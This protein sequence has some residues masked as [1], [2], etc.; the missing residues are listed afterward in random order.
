MTLYEE[1]YFDIT[2]CGKKSDLKKFIDYIRSG[3][4]DD[5]FEIDPEYI[6][7][8]ET[9]DNAPIDC[10]D[11]VS[12][13]I[14]NDDYAIE[15]E[16]LDVYDFLDSFC[17]AARDLEVEGHF[18]DTDEEYKFVSRRGSTRFE[19]ARRAGSFQEDEYF[20]EIEKRQSEAGY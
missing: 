15:I 5:F 20:D 18:Y 8:D 7:T 9:Y 1:L 14:T 19:N 16:E 2:L 12:I 6:V 4:L 11:D 3:E 17:R 10:P 13:S